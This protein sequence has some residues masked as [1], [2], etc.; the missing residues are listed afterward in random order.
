M[1]SISPVYRILLKGIALTY[2]L[3]FSIAFACSGYYLKEIVFLKPVPLIGLLKY[4]LLCVLFVILLF[5]TVKALTLSPQYLSKFYRSTMNFKWLFM[6]ALI[7][8]VA[9]KLGL[10]DTA[11]HQQ[12]AVDYLQIGILLVLGIFC[13]WSDS[14]L[15]DHSDPDAGT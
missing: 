10:F 8:S 13:F 2:M 11:L 3:L 15:K 9:A 6:I 5:N 1:T 7:I 12:V 4:L 14:I